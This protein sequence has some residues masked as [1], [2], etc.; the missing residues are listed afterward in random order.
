ML[1][2]TL[3]ANLLNEVNMSKYHIINFKFLNSNKYLY[4]ET[5]ICEIIRLFNLGYRPKQIKEITNASICVI[6]NVI[7]NQSWKFLK[8]GV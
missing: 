2:Y 5:E 7:G 6:K 3:C 8:K 1:F 4:S